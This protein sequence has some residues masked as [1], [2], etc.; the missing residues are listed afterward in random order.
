MQPLAIMSE[1]VSSTK[2]VG[3]YIFNK[4]QRYYRAHPEVKE[5]NRER[6]RIRRAVEKA[7]RNRE[8]STS[9]LDCPTINKVI[10]SLIGDRPVLA[11]TA[12][13]N[14]IAQVKEIYDKVSLWTGTS[15]WL[16]HLESEFRE[17][18]TGIAPSPYKESIALHTKRGRGIL[19]DIHSLHGRIPTNSSQRRELW[20]VK[21]EM[22]EV[23]VRDITLL[24][25][26]ALISSG[27][28]EWDDEEL[29]AE[30]GDNEED[31]EEEGMEANVE[32]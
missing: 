20:R 25:A 21:T 3:P 4:D 23:L 27:S 13:Y 28:G 1:P 26:T 31:L 10:A 15:V 8:A 18:V 5:K 7:A 19:R 14:K 9:S 29:E 24:E 22:A 16:Q 17:S 30:G 2:N 6:S 32:G 11:A 12:T